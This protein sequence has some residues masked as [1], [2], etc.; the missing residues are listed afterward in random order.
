MI[1]LD[2]KVLEFIS[3]NFLT[4]GLILGFLKGLAKITKSTTDDK[5]VTLI[6]NLFSSVKKMKGESK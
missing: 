1:A 3:G 2:T 5:I 4:I 6:S